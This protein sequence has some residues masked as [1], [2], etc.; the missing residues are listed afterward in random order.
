MNAVALSF[1]S[2][3]VAEM[4]NEVA[5]FVDAPASS[6]ALALVFGDTVSQRI[7]QRCQLFF[8]SFPFST[9]MSVHFSAD[10]E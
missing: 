9:R 3:K 1:K 7:Q 4:F 6:M 5:N 10:L 8:E 2:T